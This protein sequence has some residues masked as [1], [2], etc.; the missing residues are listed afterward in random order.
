MLM[1]TARVRRISARLI[2]QTQV[3][4]PDAADW[5][6]DVNVVTEPDINASC[7]PGGKIVVYTGLIEQ[8]KLTDPELATVIGHEMARSVVENIVARPCHV[9]TSTNRAWK[10]SRC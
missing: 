9:P 5:K 4:R 8:L 3:F 6:W 7:M 2:K 1:K 10:V